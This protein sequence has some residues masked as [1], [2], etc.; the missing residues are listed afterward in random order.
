MKKTIEN[1]FD[2]I[3]KYF[4][5]SQPFLDAIN[6][7]LINICGINTTIGIVIRGLFLLFLVF[8]VALIY[9]KKYAMYYYFIIFIYGLL[10][11]IGNSI[12]KV[13]NNNILEIKE[14]IKTFYFPVLLISLYSIRDKINI[15]ANYLLYTIGIYLIFLFIP[16]IF[17][18]GF[19]SYEITKTGTIGIFYSAN[20]ISAILSILFSFIFLLI[21]NNKIFS[22][23]IMVVGYIIVI[24]N[25][26]TKTPIIS[27]I[28]TCLI[29][30]AIIIIKNIKEKKY[31]K[32]YYIV[33]IILISAASITLFLPKT[34]F[35]RN[36]K[37]HLEFLQIEN[38]AD[39]FKKKK[40]IDHFIFSE[41]LS[42]LD[43]KNIIYEQKNCYQKLFGIGYYDEGK[44]MKLI[45]MDY[46][47]VYY[48]HGIIGYIL[49][50]SVYIYILIKIIKNIKIE[51]NFITVKVI[52][53]ILILLLTLFTGHIIV[54]PAVSFLSICIILCKIEKSHI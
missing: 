45:E 15:K 24:L 9:K 4:I 43:D 16:I 23:L 39:V 48:N 14:M 25:I 5:I 50:F 17:N 21:N 13:Q 52:S 26:G 22:F 12:Y 29:V 2:S 44:A 54:A 8:S 28:I 38:I 41:R 47:D 31:K 42:F 19:E 49:Y 51:N 35:Y 33:I 40:M 30:L 3:L 27:L 1:N 32:I 11:I 46:F 20:E 53:I 36:L 37:V 6:A 18:T 34:A 7:F 10:Y